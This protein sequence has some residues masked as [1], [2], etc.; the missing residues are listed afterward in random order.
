MD[1]AILGTSTVGRALAEGLSGAGHRVRLGTREPRVTRARAEPDQ[2]GNPPLSQWLVEHEGIDLCAYPDCAAWGEMVINATNGQ[3]SLDA[4]R[5]AGAEHLAGKVLIDVA[6]PLDFSHGFP[7][8]LSVSQTDS[9]GEQIQRTF[10]ESRVVKT[11]NTLTAALMLNPGRLAAP[12]AVFL[13]GDDADAKRQVSEL[14]AGFGWQQI[15]DL[16]GIETARGVEM[17]MPMWLQLMG[18]FGDASFNWAVVR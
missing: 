18:M 10:P 2:Y 3:G 12:S 8:R 11:L 1:I 4:L 13:S 17:L 15:L 9:L 16:G 5:A 14:L 7:P 6:N